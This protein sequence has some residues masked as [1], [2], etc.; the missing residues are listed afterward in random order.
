V[1]RD[2]AVTDAAAHY[3]LELVFLLGIP[4]A[5]PR[6]RLQIALVVWIAAHADRDQVIFLELAHAAVNARSGAIWGT[7]YSAGNALTSH[8]DN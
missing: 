7:V 1:Q 6:H 3:V 2:R 4:E 5:E 8:F